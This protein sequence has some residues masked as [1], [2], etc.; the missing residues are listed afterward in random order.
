MPTM[1]SVELTQLWGLGFGNHQQCH[2][3]AIHCEQGV[4]GGEVWEWLWVSSGLDTLSFRYPKD[5][6]LGMSSKHLDIWACK[7]STPEKIESHFI[8]PIPI[9][10]LKVLHRGQPTPLFK[11][12]QEDWSVSVSPKVGTEVMATRRVMVKPCRCP[13]FDDSFI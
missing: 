3:E 2:R 8:G 9:L 7:T 12:K 1:G 5:T 6:E 4:G 13:I 11:S 10:A